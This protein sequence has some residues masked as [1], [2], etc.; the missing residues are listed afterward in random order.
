[1]ASFEA[2]AAAFASQLQQATAA[3]QEPATHAEANAW[4]LELG[5]AALGD[6]LVVVGHGPP[7]VG[8]V[9][10]LEAARAARPRRARRAKV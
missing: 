6:A 9:A 2:E 10:A 1:M 8:R 7:A 5:A 4:L 3:L